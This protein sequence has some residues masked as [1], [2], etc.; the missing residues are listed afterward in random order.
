[1]ED[2]FLYLFAGFLV[3]FL[4]IIPFGP[5]NLAV[6]KTIIDYDRRNGIEIAFVASIIETQQVL[7]AICF[8]MLI[9]SSLDVNFLFEII[10]AFI[11][12]AL[13]IFIFTL[14]AK[15]VL[16]KEKNRPASF[17]QNGWISAGLNL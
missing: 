15:P 11:F 5:I 4:G 1:M 10:L 6:V 2:P 13:V 3:C 9:S 8:S 14:K 17:F 16:G 12:I 7:I